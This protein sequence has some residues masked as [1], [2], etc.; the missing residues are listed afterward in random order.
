MYVTD[1]SIEGRARLI[2]AYDRLVSLEHPRLTHISGDFIATISI[3]LGTRRGQ[4]AA[5]E[6]KTSI[7]NEFWNACSE[8]R[9]ESMLAMEERAHLAVLA[10]LAEY[11]S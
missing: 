2:G 10:T 3:D 9:T 8:G 1:K 11:D 6:V 5:Q 4:R 7:N